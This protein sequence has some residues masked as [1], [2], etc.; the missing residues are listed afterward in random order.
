MSQE[1]VDLVRR[2]AEA[3]ERRDRE[4]FF[5]GYSP[6]VVIEQGPPIPDGRTYR[7]YG[8]LTQA[9]SEWTK[10]FGELVMTAEE[11][12]EAGD[13]HVIVRVHQEAR[14]AGSGIP[15]AFDTWYLYTVSGG[16][17]V[18]LTM[19]GDKNDALKAVELSE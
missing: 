17:I 1:N 2:V 9:L 14:G 11:F 13:D 12:I 10:V 18:G 5:D 7:G 3:A 19:F 6:E 8:G 16:K 15:V 4:A